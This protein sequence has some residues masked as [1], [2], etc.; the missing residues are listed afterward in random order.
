VVHLVPGRHPRQVVRLQ[1]AHHPVT[2]FRGHR[3][4]QE[5]RLPALASGPDWLASRECD[6]HEMELC[7]CVH[8]GQSNAVAPLD[9]V[10][11]EVHVVLGSHPPTRHTCPRAHGI[12]LIQVY[13]YRT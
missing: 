8:F 6:F 12:F 7:L 4:L 10:T 2:H 9:S 13:T 11:W 1:W 5:Q 3:W